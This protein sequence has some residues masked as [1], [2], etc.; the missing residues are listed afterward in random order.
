MGR[1]S[2]F[3]ALKLE[4][5]VIPA[6]NARSCAGC[7]KCTLCFQAC[8][9]KAIERVGGRAAIIP[10]R[11]VGCGACVPVCP[12]GAVLFPGFTSDEQSAGLAALLAADQ[13]GQSAPVIT[14][15]SERA[16]KALLRAT[17][18]EDPYPSEV[19]PVSVPSLAILGVADL[20][21]AFARGSA[22]VGKSV[23]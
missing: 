8:P 11:C 3:Q 7:V 10:E 16:E 19:L 12:T 17:G 13:D 4:R 9:A 1:R 20:L 18:L 23:V 2:L 6:V 21:E 5:Q 22:A 15:I 14:F